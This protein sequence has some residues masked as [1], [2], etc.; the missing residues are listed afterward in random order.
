MI[1]HKAK[2]TISAPYVASVST[3]I[4]DIPEDRPSSNVIDMAD[5]ENKNTIEN[6]ELTDIHNDDLNLV[7]P[8]IKAA[9]ISK[10]RNN[11]GPSSTYVPKQCLVC[12]LTQ[13]EF[14]LSLNDLHDPSDPEKCCLRGPKY[15]QD[16]NIRERVLQYN[17]KHPIS[18]HITNTTITP[19]SHTRPPSEPNLQFNKKGNV[20]TPPLTSED[21]PEPTEKSTTSTILSL[22]TINQNHIQSLIDYIEKTIHL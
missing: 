19:A 8:S 21:L 15:I 4:M 17:L 22:P 14:H 13:K 6:I 10:P 1:S 20:S 2:H 7:D 18:K 9:R 12:G 16:K 3:P 11:N 5:V